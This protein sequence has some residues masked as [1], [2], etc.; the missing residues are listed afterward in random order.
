MLA[1][2]VE[3]PETK[4]LVWQGNTSGKAEAGKTGRGYGRISINSHS[5]AVHRVAYML[6]YGYL[7]SKVHVDHICQNRLC[8]NPFHLERTTHKKNMRRRDGVETKTAVPISWRQ[9]RIKQL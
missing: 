3:D 7:P 1:L 5:A 6:F 4:C 9:F 2:S 8:F